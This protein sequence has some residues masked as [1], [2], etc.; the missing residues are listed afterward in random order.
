[1]TM[2]DKRKYR[3]YE[4][5]EKDSR[6]IRTLSLYPGEWDSVICCGMTAVSL[7][8][9]S[10]NEALSYVALSYVWGNES[11][12]DP[13]QVNGIEID[14]TRNL[15][16]ALQHLRK[17][18]TPLKLWVDAVCINQEDEEEKSHQIYL[19]DRI[20]KQCSEGYIWLGC[21]P[22][23]S[24]VLETV[25][26]TVGYD[27]FELI[28]H[29][30]D[31]KHLSEL[32][33]FSRERENH[34]YSFKVDSNFDRAWAGLSDVIQS[35]WWARLWTV[36]EAIL[37]PTVTLIYGRSRISW[38][39]LLEATEKCV[40]H[41]WSCCGEASQVFP[42]DVSDELHVF[43]RWILNLRLARS[44]RGRTF[45][46]CDL[47]Q[48]YGHRE[49]KDPKDKIFGL[50]ALVDQKKYPTLIP[51]CNLDNTTVF[52]NA[53]KAILDASD[54]KLDW[55]YGTGYD[56][57]GTALPSWVGKNLAKPGDVP[58][59]DLRLNL[60]ALCKGFY[61]AS[62][63]RPAKLVFPI[64][65]ELR[66]RG[67][68]V[69]TLQSGGRSISRRLQ[70]VARDVVKEW[71]EMASLQELSSE[72]GSPPYNDR[73]E[74]F[75]RTMVGGLIVRNDPHLGPDDACPYDVR[76]YERAD[77]ESFKNWLF[78]V[79]GGS[80]RPNLT[81][82]SS[83]WAAIYGRAFF[84]TKQSYMGLSYPSIEVGD[85]VWVLNGARVPFILRPRLHD[86]GA[87]S[88]TFVGDCYLDGFMHGEAIDNPRHS[89][90]DVIL[91]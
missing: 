43:C 4:P 21:N 87:Y 46:L 41:W 13:V 22:P 27:H 51:D 50:L 53:A 61:F 83:T 82:E 1:V 25:S 90:C 19:M 39:K 85:E 24:S 40:R 57:Q 9:I 10:D 60:L 89:E 67:V 58:L 73:T 88:Y 2:R 35:P 28:H 64:P 52:S 76:P 55:L 80:E 31:D 75:W 20:Y 44:Q 91:K 49:C 29:F 69:D 34:E 14:V 36:Q 33:C 37:P 66:L 17:Q 11:I 6:E 56:W 45:D 3:K 63:D 47:L 81:I 32:S 38:T 23:G 42:K 5:L 30:R 62:K 65:S 78:W 74:S 59:S 77:F 86:S 7:D 18:D 70:E 79:I 8:A 15:K 68:R 26:P 12:T 54:G 71:L 16:S 84:I 72:A 48:Q